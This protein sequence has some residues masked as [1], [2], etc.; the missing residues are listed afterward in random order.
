MVVEYGQQSDTQICVG[1]L[2]MLEG[3]CL[4]HGVLGQ[5][6]CL[7]GIASKRGSVPYESRELVS[8]KHLE[9]GQRALLAAA[10]I[11]F[12]AEPTPPRVTP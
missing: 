12:R 7:V 4:Q 10:M 5:I 6:E 11:L 8:N 9:I 2:L 1:R 3:Q